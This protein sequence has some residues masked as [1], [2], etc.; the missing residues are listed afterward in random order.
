MAAKTNKDQNLYQNG[1][2]YKLLSSTNQGMTLLASILAVQMT[3]VINWKS[4]SRA[5]DN[6]LFRWCFCEKR[7]E[8]GSGKGL[9]THI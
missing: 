3:S 7:K 5:T 2:L 8:G 4:N 9:K 1:P 6:N